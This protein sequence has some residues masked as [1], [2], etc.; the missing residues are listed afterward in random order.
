M[1]SKRIIRENNIFNDNKEL[2]TI[3]ANTTGLHP[4]AGTV[5]T[6]SIPICLTKYSIINGTFSMHKP[7]TKC[8]TDA[9]NLKDIYYIPPIGFSSVDILQLYKIDSIDDLDNWLNKNL[10]N[11]TYFT[12]NRVLNAWIRINY[13]L[14]IN[15]NKILE[16]IINKII[17]KYF[18]DKIDKLKINLSKKITEF[19]DKW[20]KNNSENNYRLNLIDD[21]MDNLI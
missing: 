3:P 6:I 14:L 2:L 4:L 5:D 17:L 8:N 21:F 10:D 1:K 19:V 12:I 7:N 18:N 20:I 13:S 15:H 11:K 16:K 9:K